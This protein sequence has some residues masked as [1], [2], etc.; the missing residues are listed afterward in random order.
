MIIIMNLKLL[1]FEAD[2]CK[3]CKEQ[4][5]VLDKLTIPI[6]KINV[7]LKP[8]YVEDFD[9]YSLPTM[10]LMEGDNILFRWGA[11]TTL[12]DMQQVIDRYGE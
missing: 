9:V 7:D 1:K 3:C 11:T 4:D 6:E 8:E 5:E 12:E 10:L 2:W